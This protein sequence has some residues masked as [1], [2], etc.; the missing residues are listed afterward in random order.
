MRR[1]LSTIN[2]LYGNQVPVLLGDF[3]YARAFHLSLQ[4]QDLTC[5]RVLSDATQRICQGEMTQVLHRQDYRLDEDLYFR[6]IGDKTASL[7]GAAAR[8][9]AHYAG[10]SVAECERWGR[11]G[12]DLGTAFQVVDDVLDLEGDE[13]VVGKSLGTDLAGGKCTLPILRM[14]AAQDP[15]GRQRLEKVLAAA[16]REDTE[17]APLRLRLEQEFGLQEGLESARSEAVRLV[18]RAIGS[19]DGIAASPSLEAL[20]GLGDYVLARRC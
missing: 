13:K 2:A 5:S 3:I 12:F 1:Q 19:L 14:L 6:I 20:R 7:Y 15:A 17:T 18:Q 16:A 4:M 9:G 11:Y 10:A 8:L